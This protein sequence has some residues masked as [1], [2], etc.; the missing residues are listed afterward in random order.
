MVLRSF[1]S[2]KKG[3]V[4]GENLKEKKKKKTQKSNFQMN[5]NIAAESQTCNV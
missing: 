3:I 1:G 5:E 2:V 4:R